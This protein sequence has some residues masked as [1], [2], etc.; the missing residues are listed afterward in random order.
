MP[1]KFLR[2]ATKQFLSICDNY[3][4]VIKTNKPLAN[5]LITKLSAFLTR[6]T[7]IKDD[8]LPELDHQYL[9]RLSNLESTIEK[10]ITNNQSD[11]HLEGGTI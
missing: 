6:H 7:F 2:K 1:R 9:N 8:I 11:I 5:S 10:F 3:L 4:S